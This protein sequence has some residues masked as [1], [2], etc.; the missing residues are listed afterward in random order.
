MNVAGLSAERGVRPITG[1]DS[2]GVR[3]PRGR[4]PH[5]AVRLG[6]ADIRQR[7]AGAPVAGRQAAGMADRRQAEY[8]RRLLGQN[9]RH[10]DHRIGDIRKAIATAEAVGDAEGA[11]TL[12]RLARTEEHD[13]RTVDD[14]LANLQ[15]RF[16]VRM[17]FAAQSR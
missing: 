3:D 6:P 10:I 17:R 8:F 2:R 7:A 12:R 16:P 13:R 1:H 9:R 5:G 15:R 4:R 14:L 11:V